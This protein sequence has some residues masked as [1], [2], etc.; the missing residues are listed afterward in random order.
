MPDGLLGGAEA[1]GP[2]CIR[3]GRESGPR[4]YT[5]AVIRAILFD[6]NGVLLDDEPLHKEL[7]QELLA[8]HGVELTEDDYWSVYVGF[9]DR[10][11]FKHGFESAGKALDDGLLTRLIARKAVLYQ[12]RIEARGFPFFPGAVELV[13]A[14]HDAGLQLGVVSGA[15]R[16]EIETALDR[17]GAAQYFGPIVSADDVATS[18][19]D[20]EGYLAGI[21]AL[22]ATPPLPER[23]IHPHEILSIE[24]TPAGLEAARDAGLRRLAVEHT[25]P[26]RV[27][28]PLAEVVVEKISDA[29]PGLIRSRFA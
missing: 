24:D 5:P 20:P 16:S 22:N 3:V 8:E 29:D 26:E 10:E 12:E 9:D 21:Q 27:V 23:L 13:Q 7:L 6:F 18:K 4:R 11:A 1:A 17:A 25:F 28:G 2:K 15:L 19:P 14:V